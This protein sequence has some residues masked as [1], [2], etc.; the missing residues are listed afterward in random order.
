M[1]TNA[2]RIA[3]YKKQNGSD[4]LTPTQLR[5]VKAKANRERD[6]LGG[7]MNSELVKALDNADTETPLPN[8]DLIIKHTEETAKAY[9]T[10]AENNPD[11]LPREAKL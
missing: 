11:Q 7:K 9:Q 5:R 6:Q 2:E 10:I 4:E 3:L 8:E 1:L